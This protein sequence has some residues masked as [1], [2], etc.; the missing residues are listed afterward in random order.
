[1]AAVKLVCSVT[2]RTSCTE[3]CPR[4]SSAV[5]GRRGKARRRCRLSA[6]ACCGEG[7]YRTRSSIRYALCYAMIEKRQQHYYLHSLKAIAK[8]KVCKRTT[9]L[10]YVLITSHS[11][12]TERH[13]AIF[14][15]PQLH[16]P[17][18]QRCLPA[19]PHHAFSTRV[20]TLN[21]HQHT[22]PPQY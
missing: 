1:M 11:D 17:L 7:G 8:E 19:R 22:S 2:S 4:L 6:K 18:T 13:F 20:C 9:P 16:S 14:A 3:V 15:R 5:C 12:T 10:I 21:Q